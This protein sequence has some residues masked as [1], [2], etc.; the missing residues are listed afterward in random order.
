MRG[1]IG[2]R[3]IRATVF[4]SASS[5]RWRD[6]QCLYEAGRYQGAIYLCGYALECQLKANVCK[7]RGVEALEEGEAKKLGHELV[8]ILDAA[9]L[10]RKLNE[11]EDL[12]ATFYEI[13]RRWSTGIRYSGGGSS[14]REC[15]R[16]LKDSEALLLW[17]KT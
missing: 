9:R 4:K 10:S 13:V 1:R 14:E 15:Q 12:H 11:N 17:P 8:H 2:P 5:E 7:A 16:F 6:A 3:V